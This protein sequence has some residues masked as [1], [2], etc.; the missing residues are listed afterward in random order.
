MTDELRMFAG[1]VRRFISEELAPHQDRWRAQH[2]PDASAWLAA[3]RAGVLLPDVPESYGG[4]GGTF[5]HEAVVQEELAR[6]VTPF[7]C[8]VQ[9]IVARYLLEFATEAQKRAWL[10]RMARGELVA[11]IAMSEAGAGSD[12]QA[13]KTSAR[14]D[15]DHYVMNGSKTFVTNGTLAGLVCVAAKTNPKAPGPSGIS[16]IMVETHALSGY[17]V[18]RSLEKVGRQAQDTTELFFE[19]VHVPA[20]NLLGATEGKGF[21]QMMKQ[22]PYERLQIGVGASATAEQAVVL[23]TAY[24]KERVAFGKPLLELQNTRFKLA[25]CK[26]EAH[27]GRVFLD[28]C[29]QRQLDGQLDAVTAAMAKYWLTEASCRIVDACVQL[30]GGYGYMLEYPIARMWADSRVERIYGGANEIMKEVIGWSL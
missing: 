25:E 6:A 9:S 5:A 21:S 28:H 20:A 11:A 26:T 22:L 12:V 2:G 14:R 10:P 13:L 17:K 4:A 24:V 7:G 23:T 27:V 15:G 1:S 30:H 18:G 19:D 29:I 3:G 8:N 16:M